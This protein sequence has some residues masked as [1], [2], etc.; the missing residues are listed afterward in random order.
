MAFKQLQRYLRRVQQQ[1]EKTFEY[2]RLSLEGNKIERLTNFRKMRRPVLLLQGYGASRKVLHVLESRLRKDGFNVFSLNLGGL[3]D[4]FSTRPIPYLAHFIADKID[5]LYKRHSIREKLIVIG[6]SKGGLIGRCYLK[7]FQGHRRVKK[8]ITLATPHN[9]NPWAMLGLFT[10]LGVVT[11]SLRQMAPLSPFI[12]R[13]NRT[14]WPPGVRIVSIYSK[15]DTI[16]PY[17]S[18]V[19]RFPAKSKRLKNVE[20]EDVGH[21]EFLSKR[22]VYNLIRKELLEETS[23][24][25]RLPLPH[26]RQR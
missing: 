16:C 14:P 4:R 22:K 13:M 25:R 20:I 6:H 19:L 8:L 24:A 12:R 26:K 17:P 1:T 15:D 18:A 7:D 2:V 9:G 21:A 11:K 23:S 5:A 10:P 3:L